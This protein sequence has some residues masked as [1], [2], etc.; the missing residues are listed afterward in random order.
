MCTILF[1]YGQHDKYKLILA[2]NRDEFY[3]RETEPARWWKE[4]KN[5][6][7]GRDIQAGG[8]WLGITK[9]GR[10]AAITNYRKFPHEKKYETSRGDIVKD[11]LTSNISA[12]E[13]LQHLENTRD[14]YDG[15]NLLF[16]T[17]LG[18]FCFS[19]RSNKNGAVVAGLHGLSNHLLNTPWPKVEK[20][21]ERFKTLVN[22]EHEPN[23]LLNLMMDSTTAPDETLP[24]TGVGLE[25]ERQL[26]PIFI[27][28][29]NYGTRQTTLLLIDNRGKVTFT[30]VSHDTGIE[31]NFEFQIG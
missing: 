5:I 12:T 30:E 19:N 24:D 29:D 31:N 14:N 25:W 8:T 18:L 13:Y 22:S 20:G 15:Y 2:A 7:G 9:Q 23:D 3:S 10:F 21:K 1:S 17:S 27:K 28:M 26:S 4:D 16:G 11:F 6:L